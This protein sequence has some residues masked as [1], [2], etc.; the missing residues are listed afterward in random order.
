MKRFMFALILTLLVG[1][2]AFGASPPQWVWDE[3]GRV[4]DSTGQYRRLSDEEACK[5]YGLCKGGAPSKPAKKPVGPITSLE[6]LASKSGANVVRAFTCLTGGTTGCLDKIAVAAI[7]DGDIAITMVGETVYFHQFD[8]DGTDAESSPAVIRPNDYSTAGVW[9]LA[10]IVQGMLPDTLTG[11]SFGG[12]GASKVICSDGDGIL[13]DCTSLTDTAF[14]GYLSLAGG[15]MTGGLVMADAG[16]VKMTKSATDGKYSGM[17]LDWKAGENLAF[18]ELVYMKS[19]GKIWRADADGAATMPCIGIVVVA[20]N[21]DA[22]ATILTHGVVTETD[23]NWTVGQRL[24]VSE[25]V[26]TIENTLSNITDENDVV[27]II[28]VAIHADTI[29]FNPSLVEAVL[30]AP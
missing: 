12:F 28:G 15:T 20:A 27:Q 2:Q 7:E 1:V 25:A 13:I 10:K 18:G 26:G 9:K 16:G 30:A 3:Q 23:W 19:D 8:A 5:L 14:S 29:F 11:L 17:T 21:A 4:T 22:T 24:Y 6:E